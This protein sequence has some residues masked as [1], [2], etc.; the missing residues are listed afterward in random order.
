[1]GEAEDFKVLQNRMLEERSIFTFVMK[2]GDQL[3]FPPGMIHGT[4]VVSDECSMSLSLQFSDPSPVHYVKNWKDA[5]TTEVQGASS[6]FHDY[7]NYWMFGVDELNSNGDTND[8]ECPGLFHQFDRNSDGFVDSD[9]MK[10]ALLENPSYSHSLNDGDSFKDPENDV[11]SF[12]RLHDKNE[13]GKLWGPS[14]KRGSNR[15]L[16]NQ[17]MGREFDTLWQR[18]R[19]NEPD[20]TQEMWEDAFP[21]SQLWDAVTH[22]MDR[23][24]DGVID[25][26]EFQE[27]TENLEDIDFQKASLEPLAVLLTGDPNGLDDVLA[28]RSDGTPRV[29]DEEEEEEEEEGPPPA[30]DEL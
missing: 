18:L 14:L 5:L 17:R 4:K 16:R 1:M 3:F 7:W 6:C 12:I 11:L 24:G 9:E 13:D 30:H 19:G 21:R 8:V 10:A 22:F 2:P 26:E 20:V 23:N 28:G 27:G 29:E 15:F 25:D